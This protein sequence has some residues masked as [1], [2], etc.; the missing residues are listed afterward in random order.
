MKKVLPIL[1][2]LIL[3]V[4]LSGCGAPSGPGKTEPEFVIAPDPARTTAAAAELPDDPEG[5]ETTE[6][7]EKI[8]FRG[9][10]LSDVYDFLISMGYP[11]DQ[12]SYYDCEK[13]KNILTKKNWTVKYVEFDKFNKLQLGCVQSTTG[14]KAIGNGL[15]AVKDK[16][17]DWMTGIEKIGN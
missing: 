6:E 12:I 2:S 5:A 17:Y 11:E 10:L 14:L 8:E 13:G 1:L 7:D 3:C 15:A 4:L 9:E 16:I